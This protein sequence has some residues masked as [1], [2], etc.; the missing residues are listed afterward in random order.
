MAVMQEDGNLVVYPSDNLTPEGSIWNSQTNG[1]HGAEMLVRRD[2][3]FAIYPAG[4]I[5]RE[6]SEIIG[7][8]IFGGI[9]HSNGP[10]A[11]GD[12][13]L[14]MQDDGNLVLYAGEDP[15]KPAQAIWASFEHQPL[16]A[17][18]IV[19]WQNSATAVRSQTVMALNSAAAEITAKRIFDEYNQIAVDYYTATSYTVRMGRCQ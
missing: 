7:G 2:G 13:F 3:Y 15:G 9:F 18:C 19:L 5:S 17:F 6:T 4:M 16:T 14:S 1:H 8:P 10:G 12:Y 11:I